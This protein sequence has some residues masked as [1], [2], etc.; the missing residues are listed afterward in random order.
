MD[1][2]YDAGKRLLRGEYSQFTVYGKSYFVRANAYHKV[3]IKGDKIY[4]FSKSL[5]RVAH[6]GWVT[7][8][9]K[10]GDRYTITTVEGN[11]S[12]GD[13][14]DR[15]GGCVAEKHYTFTI[16]EV[17]GTN[18][19][20]GFGTP[21]Y[22]DSTCDVETLI[23]IA[24]QEIG[25]EEKASRDK[26]DDKHANPGKSNFTKYGEW[27]DNN[28]AY[29]CEQFASWVAYMAC[30]KF[31]EQRKAVNGWFS[32][33][34][35]WIYRVNGEL[36]KGEWKF[37]DGRWYVF[38]NAG[39]AI[40]GWFEAGDTWYYLNPDDCAMISGQWLYYKGKTYYVTKD[41]SMAKSVYVKDSEKDIYYWLNQDGEYY[42]QWD[43]ITPDLD[44]YEV[45]E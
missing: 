31:L 3:P 2:A 37:I 33:D 45:V 28:G 16:N 13:N 19:I 10:Q 30:K 8:V 4:F 38:D 1:I 25:Y 41:G 12:V 35:K 20:N 21:L 15:N 40:T 29:W 42:N 26:L 9:S 32:K 43:T 11:T 17:G 34:G 7:D 18:R 36:I 6:V 5:N 27:Y 22:S 44:K 14:F 39:Y 24:K 23:Y